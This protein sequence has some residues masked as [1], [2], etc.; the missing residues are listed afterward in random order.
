MR[1]SH[2]ASSVQ[3][4]EPHSS[5]CAYTL[6]SDS[7]RQTPTFC[8]FW[9]KSFNAVKLFRHPKYASVY[10]LSQHLQNWWGW[11]LLPYLICE[12][13]RRQIWLSEERETFS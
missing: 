1:Q 12:G 2:G 9:A 7:G 6:L 4:R 3:Q 10:T 13:G 8:I 11:C 5:V